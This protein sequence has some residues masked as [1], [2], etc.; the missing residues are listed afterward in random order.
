MALHVLGGGQPGQHPSGAGE[1]AK[2]VNRRG[3]LAIDRCLIGLSRVLHLEPGELL[4]VV[5]DG[6]GDPKQRHAP[7]RGRGLPPGL[8]GPLRRPHRGVDILCA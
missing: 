3:Q 7:L 2:L 4:G 1:E 8:E 5:L 6:V